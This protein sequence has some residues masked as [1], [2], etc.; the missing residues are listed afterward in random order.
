MS[1]FFL[2]E[3]PVLD[4]LIRRA[5]KKLHLSE[6]DV[7]IEIIEEG[8]E[9]FLGIGKKDYKIK[10]VPL[11]EVRSD[12]QSQKKKEDLDKILKDSNEK[13]SEKVNLRIEKTKDGIF[14]SSHG[15]NK[16]SLEDVQNI[17]EENQISN[18][19]YEGVKKFLESDETRTKIAEW[20]PGL[21]KDSEVIV[22]VADD[23]MQA[24]LTVTEPDG[25]NE[26]NKETIM[27]KLK[28]KGV[29][30]GIDEKS[31]DDVL[32]DKKFNERIVVANG[33]LPQSGMD[34][35][36]RYK[37]DPGEK[38]KGKLLE[39]GRID[40]KSVSNIVNV[41]KGEVLAE[42]VPPT[43]G[44]PGKDVLGTEVSPE[45]GADV[46]I[47]AFAGKG[48]R[49]SEDG[50]KIIA[51]IDGQVVVENDKLNVYPVY[52][53]DGDVNLNVGNID[54]IG[55]V[56]VKGSV[57][58]GFDIKAKGNIEV[59]NN[60]GASRVEATGDIL[61]R[62]GILGKD[63]GY[64]KSLGNIEAKFIE[65]SNI[66]AKKNIVVHK[67]VMRSQLKANRILVTESKG[68]I[69]GGTIKARDLVECI[70]L[71]SH[72]ATKTNV[73]IGIKDKILERMEEIDAEVEKI[74]DDTEKVQEA[75]D[76]L[77]T[78]RKRLGKLPDDKEEKLNKF[79]LLAEQL[80]EKSEKLMEER[81]ELEE[82]MEAGH[83][84][85]LKVKNVIY[86]GVTITIRKGIMQ[87][88]DEIKFASI[89]YDEGYLKIN[90]YS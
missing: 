28:E 37:F 26:T 30:Y 27:E 66:E 79:R 78:I 58:D 60:I 48:V 4:K 8:E 62:G 47:E 46:S 74:H 45:P 1:D 2:F 85:K 64:V 51:E 65:N 53:V 90:P 17:I 13:D 9:G 87:V 11:V 39:D 24:F 3:G 35:H 34:A 71:G 55:S 40:Y 16:G 69:V 19:D 89:I 32:L 44:E 22:E 88:K 18:V 63:T 7:E 52:V 76:S 38:K 72:F 83:S 70:T 6:K 57:L 23:D 12:K 5:L 84:G 67:A 29:V 15:E 14:I 31:F 21:Y 25:G 86:P 49:I 68:L 75:T 59:E 20:D 33:L 36:I 41:V 77:D 56:M 43:E 50:E 54:F 80:E 82:E 73:I 10:V 61:V 42:F 81:D